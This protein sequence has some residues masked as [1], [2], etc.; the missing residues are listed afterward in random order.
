M[1]CHIGKPR[2]NKEQTSFQSTQD[3]GSLKPQEWTAQ[4]L[5]APVHP[6][7]GPVRHSEELA[8][9]HP[10]PP[11]R[12]GKENKITPPYA[13]PRCILFVPQH[14]VRGRTLENQFYVFAIE[15][16]EGGTARETG[17]HL[18]NEGRGRPGT[19]VPGDGGDRGHVRARPWWQCSS[20]LPAHGTAARL[21]AR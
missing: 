16:S 12:N 7:T 9:L 3:T 19:K 15:F 13:S 14:C 5:T 8:N 18:R 11:F 1:R 6:N 17:L 21:A 2:T 20:A 4:S 10:H